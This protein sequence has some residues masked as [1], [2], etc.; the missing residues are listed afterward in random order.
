MEVE[1]PHPSYD[2]WLTDND[3]MLVFLEIPVQSSNVEYV[4]LNTDSSVPQVNAPVTVMGWGDIDESDDVSTLSNVLREVEVNVISND[5]CAESEGNTVWGETENYAHGQI[6]NNMLC[7]QEDGVDACQGDSGGPLV[8]KGTGSDGGDVQVGVVSWGIGCAHADF[9]GVYARVSAQ[10]DWIREEVCAR[11]SL[12]PA[13]FD[14]GSDTM[15]P[16]PTPNQNNPPE[17]STFVPSY[18]PT[19]S[20]PFFS[21]VE[22]VPRPTPPTFYPTLWPTFFSVGE[23]V[24]RPT[25]PEEPEFVPTFYPTLFPMLTPTSS[26]ESWT[27]SSSNQSPEEPTFAPSLTPTLSPSFSPTLSPSLSPTQSPDIIGGDNALETTSEENWLT[28]VSEDFTYG[29][30]SF[31]GDGGTKILDNSKGRFGVA[32]IQE[33]SSLISGEITLDHERHASR[34][35]VMFSFFVLRLDPEEG[36]CL[37]YRTNGGIDW[38]EERCWTDRDIA[39]K[40]WTDGMSA[41]FE[42]PHA[43]ERLR[44]RF[45]CYGDSKH[46]DVLIDAVR[47][48]ALEGGNDIGNGAELSTASSPIVEGEDDTDLPTEFPSTYT[49]TTSPTLSLT[50]TPTMSPTLSP[51]YIPTVGPTQSDQSDTPFPTY[52]PSNASPTFPEEDGNDSG[53]TF[54]FFINFSREN[55]RVRPHRDPA[56]SEA[57]G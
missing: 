31:A 9:P 26:P 45:R 49:P 15:R 10:Y 16:G 36:F 21:V 23:T 56:T 13:E 47:V 19:L 8:S 25:P 11:S 33:S 17:E 30:G 22:S 1:V 24:P 57:G 6:T 42:V 52:N 4:R 38:T 39:V 35:K 5:E 53:P 18:S 29:Y 48:L 41:E 50:L 54:S 43:T 12:P 55:V 3:F 40:R 28:L 44:I 7:A 46:D 2:A 27:I 32:N 20:P 14:C 34:F 51:T 37:D